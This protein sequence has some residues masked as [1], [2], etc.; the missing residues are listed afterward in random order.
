MLIGKSE[1]MNTVIIRLLPIELINQ[2]SVVHLAEKLMYG[3][4]NER[5]ENK[6][7]VVT[8]NRVNYRRQA[9]RE[10]YNFITPQFIRKN[11]ESLSL[12]KAVTE[13]AEIR[14]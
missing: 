3:N 4:K 7:A 1:Q 5:Q 11:R 14:R 10:V 6:L 8:Q 13:I 2:M 12:S 9:Y